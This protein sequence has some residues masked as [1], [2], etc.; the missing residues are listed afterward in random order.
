[1]S[2]TDDEQAETTYQATRGGICC[3]FVCRGS[4][5]VR[6]AAILR[7]WLQPTISSENMSVDVLRRCGFRVEVIA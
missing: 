4:R 1:M 2:K 6:H 7:Q 3:E 5:V